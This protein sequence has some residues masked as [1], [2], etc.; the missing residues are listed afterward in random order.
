MR[1][2]LHIFFCLWMPFVAMSQNVPEIQLDTIPNDTSRI[3]KE[4]TINELVVTANHPLRNI[5][6]TFMGMSVDISEYKKIPN[7]IGDADPFKALQ[8]LGGF[9]QAGEASYNMNVWGGDNDHN[10]IL[11]N[12]APVEVP[13]HALG[14][15]SIFN[16]DLMDKMDFIKSGV[17]A[18]YG[19]KV[20]SV[21][22]LKHFIHL[23]ERTEVSGNIGLISG[24]LSVK[25]P[26]TN[27]LSAYGAHRRSFIGALIVPVL[28]KA[29]VNPVF[30]ENQYEFHDTN[31]GAN[32]QFNNST[33]LGFHFYEGYDVID[34]SELFIRG[35]KRMSWR[36]K[37]YGFQLNHVFSD[38]LSMIQYLNF[39]QFDMLTNM[40]WLS[41]YYRIQT[42]NTNLRY[43]I[44]FS[45]VL[46]NHHIKAGVEMM[47][48]K[49]HYNHR[50][51]A[52]DVE[53]TEPLNGNHVSEISVY[54]RDNW[55]M[56]P[57]S[58]NAGV[59]GNL[60]L[61]HPNTYRRSL[62]AFN[63]NKSVVTHY[64]NLEPRLSM[65]WLL[66][67]ASAIKAS[68][69][70]HHQ[71]Y[72]RTQLF[73]LGVP[74]E[75]H[76]YSSER[77]KPNTLWNYS[78]GYYW[79]SG[80][81][82]WNFS[83]EGYYRKFKNLLQASGNLND[84][85]RSYSYD[86]YIIMGEGVAYGMEL[87]L[88][89]SS[90]HFDVWLKYLLG[91]NT[92]CFD[93]INNGK[94]FY[95][96]NDRRHDLTLIGTFKLTERWSASGSLFLASGN[97][98]NLP[99]SWYVIDNKI[100]PEYDGYNSFVLPVYHRMDVSATYKL[101]DYRNLRSELIFSVHNLYNRAN[102]FQFFFDTSQGVGGL[103]NFKLQRL[104][105]LPILPTVS[106][107]FYF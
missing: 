45:C 40:I 76:T 57:L 37:L 72:N 23:P 17:S 98:F 43:K 77:I 12:G 70:H 7:I 104:Y 58:I 48:G 13:T 39:T 60:F 41:D 16:P 73:S 25:T 84:Y 88:N 22:D 47:T 94:T 30:F 101:K 38:K 86:E 52:Y 105:F 53:S 5:Q 24:R 35:L 85:L 15:F 54:I 59:R 99:L 83:M 44:D 82:N 56:G 36:N 18:E 11:L 3:A 102:P 74:Y 61:K 81:K 63:E 67:D 55:D 90:K 19:G 33:R 20:S 93:E 75:L 51:A 92:R 78:L 97:R 34:I 10:L 9:S 31:F 64:K 66:N 14:L 79:T 26:I 62:F 107:S 4:I 6:S 28:M 106:W 68:L 27:K 80:K 89:R 1:F 95:A 42:E 100:I 91:W 65:R 21:V 103:H 29:G 87:S 50:D 71:N 49:L 32:Y 8:Y 46:P 96:T 2:Y 69:T